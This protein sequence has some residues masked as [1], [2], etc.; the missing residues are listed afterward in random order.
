MKN[1]LFAIAFLLV[2]IQQL[3]A[4]EID[5]EKFLDRA[6]QATIQYQETFKNLVSEELRTYDYFRKDGTLEDSRKIRSIFIVYQSPKNNAIAEFRNVIEFNGKNV[7]REDKDIVKFF[8]KLSKSDSNE[9]EIKRLRK[10]ADRFDGKTHAYG[11][12]L[13]EAFILHRLYRPSF[14]FKILGK[15]KIEGHDVIIVEYNQTKENLRI[16]VNATNEERKKEPNGI[17]FNLLDLP[18]RFRPTNPRL[19]GKLWLDAETA[20]LWRNDFTVSIQPA[21]FSKPI[22]SSEFSYQY[23]SGEYGILLPK[24]FSMTGYRFS[25]KTDADLVRNKFGTKTFEYSKF[26][27][28]D[29]QVKEAKTDK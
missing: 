17:G 22:I 8:E 6:Y 15:D 4:Q 20:Q 14:E 10:E 12:T 2:S 28:P 21:V 25:G 24:I 23:Q 7:A 9:E 11:M 18:D 16:S 19:H 26:S 3:T 5:L 27:K 29:S 1:F 13:S